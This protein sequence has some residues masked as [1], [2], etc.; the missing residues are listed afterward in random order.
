MLTTAAVNDATDASGSCPVPSAAR[1]TPVTSAEQE[2][3]MASHHE[4]E[5]LVIEPR[6][7]WQAVD[8]A[9]LYRYRELLYF[10]IWRDVKVKYKMAILGFAWAIFVPLFSMLIYGTFGL[11]LGLKFEGSSAPYMLGM[12]AGLIPWLFLQ[13]SITD[14]GQSLVNQQPLMSKIYMPR[15]F[16]P[17]A[18]CGGAMV[19]MV[20][21]TGIFVLLAVGFAASGSF[22]PT[23][24]LLAV[25]LLALLT[26][27]A[28]LGTA[29][30]LSG[31]TVLYRDLRFL[32]PF[33]TQFG[34]WLSGVAF[35][36]SIMGKYEWLLMF[37]P[38]AGIISGWRSALI[39]MP[40]QPLLLLGSLVLTPLLLVIAVVSFRRVERRFADV[41]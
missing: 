1:R 16:L 6:R 39:G 8:W 9:E 31:L 3:A 41:A 27:A 7:G 5:T 40:W 29:I 21:S 4:M 20:I 25:P 33:M 36:T 14:G 38:Y 11:L 26:V 30:L 32:I 19:D 12:Y 2:P 35:P 17:S 23:W 22:E 18:A 24:N 15:L 37:N 10:L 34:L 13:R 28:G